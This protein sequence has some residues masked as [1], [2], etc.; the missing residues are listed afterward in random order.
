MG[1]N[2]GGQTPNAGG[3]GRTPMYGGSQTPMYGGAATPMHD[4]FGGARTPHYGSMTPAYGQQSSSWDPNV[5]NT[6]AHSS[7]HFDDEFES[8]GFSG[9][10]GGGFGGATPAFGGATPGFGGATPGFGGATPAG[11]QQHRNGYGANTPSNIGS[12]TPRDGDFNFNSNFTASSPYPRSGA[13]PHRP[14]MPSASPAA[15]PTAIP[16]EFLKE[17]TWCGLDLCVIVRRTYED[18]GVH[19]LEGTI[20]TISGDKCVVYFD[21][22][23]TDKTIPKEQLLPA[24]PEEGDMAMIIFGPNK[25]TKVTLF[26]CEGDDWVVKTQKG[27]VELSHKAVLC[28]YC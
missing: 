26:K 24:P 25:N 7:S 22:L 27:E 4:S 12:T 28:K 5:A 23:D 1:S 19:G 20:R 2:L 3:Y 18:T 14:G 21:N 15:R 9:G 8:H 13:S 6:P 11:N 17:G 10:G 16:E